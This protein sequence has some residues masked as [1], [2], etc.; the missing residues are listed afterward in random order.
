MGVCVCLQWQSA[1]VFQWQCL[2]CLHIPPGRFGRGADEGT[3]VFVLPQDP[4]KVVFFPLQAVLPSG[5]SSG[6]VKQAPGQS[7]LDLGW[8]VVMEV[9]V[10]VCVCQFAVDGD[11]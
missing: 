10:L 8:V 2:V 4:G 3:G 7:P 6:S 9:Q 1:F 5:D 11:V